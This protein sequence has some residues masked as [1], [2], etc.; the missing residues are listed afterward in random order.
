MG[1]KCG[2]GGGDDQVTPLMFP[3][4]GREGKGVAKKLWQRR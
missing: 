3:D 2:V 1:V 4:P